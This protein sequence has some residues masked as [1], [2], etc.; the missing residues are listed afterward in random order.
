MSCFVST[1]GAPDCLVVP[2]DAAEDDA[3][4]FWRRGKS[5]TENSSYGCSESSIR[6]QIPLHLK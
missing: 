4:P 6:Y 1:N 2:T 3:L 5:W